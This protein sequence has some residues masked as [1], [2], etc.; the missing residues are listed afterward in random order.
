LDRKKRSAVAA[1]D[2]SADGRFVYAVK[3]TGVYCRPGCL[4]RLPRPENVA[5]FDGPADAAAAGFRPCLRCKPDE[6]QANPHSAM[7]ADLCRYIESAEESPSLDDLAERAGMSAYHFH[8]VFKRMTGLTPK[9][10]AA[11]H[12][13]ERV[14]DGLRAGGTVTEAVY[15]AGY[16][17]SSR[18]YEESDA[19]LGM[20]PKA[21]KEGGAAS[22]IRFAVGECSLGAILVAQSETGVCAILL[23]DDPDL[24]IE[25]LEQRFPRA[26][27]V[28]GDP[29]F[30]RLV[31]QVVG[32]VEAP[33]VGLDLPL[34]IRGTVFQRRVWQAL[35]A[36]PAGETASYREIAERIGAPKSVRA[37]A[38]ACAA[39][40]LAVAIPCHRVVKA[41]G[42]LSGYRWGVERKRA[43]LDR[44]GNLEQR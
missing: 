24:L 8:R 23:G 11:A 12:R 22:T 34:D 21:Y 40:G 19:V 10:Y 28:A 18:F 6:A 15:D 36:I 26:A 43:L 7:I 2:G 42:G 39:N 25:E 9:A 4:S 17:S 29:E 20:K 41:D 5:F 16:G 35:R 13:A 32:F 31:S 27:L 44:E 14:R 38:G 37:V 33:R 30:E 1:R 3:T